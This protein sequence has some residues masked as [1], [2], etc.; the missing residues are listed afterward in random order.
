MKKYS[1][2][3]T[4]NKNKKQVEFIINATSKN[5]AKSIAI[6][7]HYKDLGMPGHVND[8]SEVK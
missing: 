5:E 8:V 1:V 2:L 4:N 6:K 7:K 3:L